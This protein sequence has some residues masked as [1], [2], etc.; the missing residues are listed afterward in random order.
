M[1]MKVIITGATGLVGEGVL[2]E[3]LEQPTVEE[4]LIVGRKPYSKQH[5]KLKEL[6]VP[7]F[8]Q[9]DNVENSLAGYDACF[10]CAG[11]SAIGMKEAE[12]T[13]IT[14]D[15]TMHF[16]A[17]LARLNP[18]MVFNHISGQGTDSSESGR[19][20]WARVKG[21]TENALLKLPFKAVYNFRPGMMKPTSGQQNI[22]PI[23]KF[24]AVLY[25]VFHVITPN[26]TSTLKDVGRAMIN[27]VLKGYHKQVLEVKDINALAKA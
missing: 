1:G 10:Y 18:A 17:T 22:K 14:Y 13:R 6:I 26:S 2:L 16:A 11:I 12:Y 7:D 23:F 21:K 15:T 25:P 4:V 24:M 27:A 9:L 8:L 5:P 20:M 19:M 3:C